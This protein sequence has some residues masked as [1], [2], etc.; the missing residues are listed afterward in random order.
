MS[1]SHETTV[2]SQV[3]I[4]LWL[5]NSLPKSYGATAGRFDT[6]LLATQLKETSWQTKRMA[7]C[8]DRT[9]RCIPAG[10]IMALD[11][12]AP[13]PRSQMKYFTATFLVRECERTDCSGPDCLYKRW[14]SLAGLTS[15]LNRTTL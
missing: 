1:P 10:A 9:Q 3:L 2:L 7:L 4:L 8:G 11:A 5:G 13:V 6:F 14:S 12:N 15:R